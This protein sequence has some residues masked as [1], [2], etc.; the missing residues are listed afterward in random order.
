MWNIEQRI[1]FISSHKD[2]LINYI[3]Y[4][5]YGYFLYVSCFTSTELV[6]RLSQLVQSINKFGASLE[7]EIL[8]VAFLTVFPDITSSTSYLF[9][10]RCYHRLFIAI[11]AKHNALTRDYI[12]L[13]N[14]QNTLQTFTN[15][16]LDVI[17]H[18]LL[19]KYLV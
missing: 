19:E 4:S 8:C 15:L 14:L 6:E 11:Q 18:V 12:G 9:V 16:P 2:L 17:K 3:Q 5:N 7:E 1:Q 10:T 13:V